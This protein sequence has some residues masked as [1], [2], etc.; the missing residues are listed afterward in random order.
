ML[1]DVHHRHKDVNQILSLLRSWE[2]RAELANIVLSSI[3]IQILLLLLHC[4]GY[5]RKIHSIGPVFHEDRFLQL[6][7]VYQGKPSAGC[8]N[9]RKRK[10]KVY[11]D[12]SS[13]CATSIDLLLTV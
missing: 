5:L 8:A 7:M 11:L 10:I 13:V 12:G 1:N 4:K 2:E 6:I 3:D 9:C